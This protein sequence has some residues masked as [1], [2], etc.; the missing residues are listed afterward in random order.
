MANTKKK[1]TMINKHVRFNSGTGEVTESEEFKVYKMPS[2]PPFVKLYV[3]DLTAIHNLPS[4]TSSIL[5]ELVKKMNYEG[6]VILNSYVKLEIMDRLGI[7]PTKSRPT[8]MFDNALMKLK[9]AGIIEQISRG[10]Y[11][12][13]P[14]YFAKGDWSEIRKRREKFELSITYTENG[15]RVIKGEF[16]KSTCKE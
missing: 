10:Y 9:K 4:S 5:F 15:E 3:Q 6:T 7:K 1:V 8:Q 13:N 12:F 14:H 11:E 2:E 16:K